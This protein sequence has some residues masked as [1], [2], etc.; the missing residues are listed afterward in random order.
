MAD[1]KKLPLKVIPPL[2]TDF[3]HP[4]IAGG[5]KKIFTKVT[6]EFRQKQIGRASCRERV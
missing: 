5:P 2:E 3:Y 4:D 6:P 1:N